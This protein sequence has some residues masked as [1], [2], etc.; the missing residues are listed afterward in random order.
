MSKKRNLRFRHNQYRKSFIHSG[1]YL[2]QIGLDLSVR[3]IIW[4][5]EKSEFQ[6][7]VLHLLPLILTDVIGNQ[8]WGLEIISKFVTGTWLLTSYFDSDVLIF[9]IH[10][11]CKAGFICFLA[12]YYSLKSMEYNRN[13]ND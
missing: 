12:R 7:Y 5:R 4:K 1:T 8:I 2:L 9:V 10:N 13:F 6:Q 3:Y 11:L